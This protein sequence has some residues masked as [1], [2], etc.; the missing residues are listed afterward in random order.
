MRGDT[1]KFGP[2]VRHGIAPPAF[3]SRFGPFPLT[4]GE[5]YLVRIGIMVDEDFFFTFGEGPFTY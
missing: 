2:M 5:T 1:G 4:D 3:T